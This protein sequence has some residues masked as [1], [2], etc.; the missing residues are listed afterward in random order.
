MKFCSK[1]GGKNLE[2]SNFCENCGNKLNTMSTSTTQKTT[3]KPTTQ[4]NNILKLYA[5]SLKKYAEFKGR[6][7]RKEY[8]SFW[9]MNLIIGTIL[10]IVDK[11]INSTALALYQLF[12]FL[13]SI[14]IGVRRMHDTGKSGLFILI[15]LLNLIFFLISG[16]ENENKYGKKPNI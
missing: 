5:E 6:A 1:C 9:L 16:D 4:K 8:W 10:T 3:E 11:Y 14:S 7:S 15:P 2:N 13:P 12:T